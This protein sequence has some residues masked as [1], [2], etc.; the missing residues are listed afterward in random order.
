MHDKSDSQ[1]LSI[2]EWSALQESAL[3]KYDYTWSLPTEELDF[4]GYCDSLDMHWLKQL[5]P[6][7]SFL[8]PP[9]LNNFNNQ[10]PSDQANL[11]AFLAMFSENHTFLSFNLHHS[12]TSTLTL[13]VVYISYN[14][15]YLNQLSLK[16]L[17]KQLPISSPQSTHFYFQQDK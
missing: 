3:F 17:K 12:H 14:L 8:L 6:Y 10:A 9:F 11:N 7:Y 5:N 16:Y 2:A 15:E 1:V 4:E 13:R